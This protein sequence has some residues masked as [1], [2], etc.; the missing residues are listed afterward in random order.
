MKTTS[1]IFLDFSRFLSISLDLSSH[2][3]LTFF[4]Y[5]SHVLKKEYPSEMTV[6][7]FVEVM[8]DILQAGGIDHIE[9]DVFPLKDLLLFITVVSP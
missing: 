8:T 3:S 9:Y 5:L 7:E 1:S 6:A 2:S 4:N